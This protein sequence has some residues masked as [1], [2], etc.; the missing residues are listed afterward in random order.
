MKDRHSSFTSAD[1]EPEAARDIAGFPVLAVT[2]EQLA[3]RLAEAWRTERQQCLFFVNTN[4]VNRCGLLRPRLSEPSVTLVNDGI[5][6]DLACWLL[7]GHRFPENLNGTDFVPWFLGH[8][9]GTLPEVSA[10]PKVFLFGAEEGIARRAGQALTRQGVAVVG[11]LNGFGEA[12]SVDAVVSAISESGAEVILVAMGNP[13]QERWILENRHRLPA[14]R[15]LIGVGALFDFLAGEKPR[16][17][18]WIRRFRLEWLYRLS[19]EPRR[20]GRR[21][22]VDIL[23]FLACCR[24]WHKRPKVS[25]SARGSDPGR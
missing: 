16:A 15:L 20:L 23:R 13:G 18:Q 1:P 25:A 2:R 11:T 12:K 9:A 24:Q 7:H 4:F 6:M 22:T 5:G 21:Y 14:A 10:G 8:L 3:V 19:L 17:P